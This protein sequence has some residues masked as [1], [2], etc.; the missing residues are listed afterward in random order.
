M[1]QPPLPQSLIRRLELHDLLKAI[2]GVADAY[3]QPP[4]SDKMVYPCIRYERSDI[5]TAFAD[6]NPYRHA[7]RYQLTVIDSDPDSLIPDEVAKLPEC[8]FDRHYTADNL[9]HDI[10]N[11]YY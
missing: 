2:P 8:T 1:A 7:K 5:D 10:F 11:L 9:N 4:S 3:F 6:N